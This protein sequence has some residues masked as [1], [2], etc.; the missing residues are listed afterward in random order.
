MV[1]YYS[2]DQQP[3]HPATEFGK[4]AK[5]H[6]VANL[7]IIIIKIAS[8]NEWE[9]TII[10]LHKSSILRQRKKNRY[11]RISDFK[12]KLMSAF[13]FNKLRRLSCFHASIV[14]WQ[15]FI[16]DNQ[17]YSFIFLIESHFQQIS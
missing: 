5:R 6:I 17:F 1:R 10:I 15:D 11:C 13:I 7:V 8:L 14:H 12:L 2:P 3:Q 16:T 4:A 9:F